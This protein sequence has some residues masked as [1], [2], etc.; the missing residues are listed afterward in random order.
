MNG[1]I[2]SIKN[3]WFCCHDWECVYSGQVRYSN[4]WGSCGWYTEIHLVCRKC[5]KH[6]VVKAGKN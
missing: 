4:I 5:G 2:E 3:K 1:L 6:K